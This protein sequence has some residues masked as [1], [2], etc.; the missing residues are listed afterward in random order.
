MF[1]VIQIILFNL[2]LHPVLYINHLSYN[3]DMLAI[4]HCLQYTKENTNLLKMK[5]T[6]SLHMYHV[7]V[8][9]YPL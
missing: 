4:D 9:W 7:H 2:L 3:G 8:V 5:G 1:V 6:K